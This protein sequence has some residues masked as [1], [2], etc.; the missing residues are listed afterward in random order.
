METKTF[1]TPFR[2]FKV[3]I[4]TYLTAEDEFEI[5]KVMYNA[6]EIKGGVVA[7]VAGST[8]E[9][10]KKMEEKV[11]EK[12]IVSIDGDKEKIIKRIWE[13]PAQ[14][15]DFIKAE[16]DKMRSYEDIKKK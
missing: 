12:A 2:G 3:E 4:K 7:D 6:A 5:Q 16:I 14:D 15:Y 9:V 1:E 10:M 13:M 11:M 8:G